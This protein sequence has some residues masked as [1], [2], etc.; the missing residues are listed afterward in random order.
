MLVNSA[1]A[2]YPSL[3]FQFAFDQAGENFH[4]AALMLS[5]RGF[6]SGYTVVVKRIRREHRD[7]SD[8]KIGKTFRNQAENSMFVW[9]AMTVVMV[10]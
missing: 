10:G 1:V 6:W 7:K 5:G 4:T 2:Q 8:G 3:A 9:V